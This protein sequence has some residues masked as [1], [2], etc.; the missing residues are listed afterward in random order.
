MST[1]Y[2]LPCDC[3]AKLE[4][5]ATESGLTKAC[6]CGALLQ[7]PTL[8]G[9]RQLEVVAAD[10]APPPSTWGTLQRGITVGT[11]IAVLGLGFAIYAGVAMGMTARE[12]HQLK[13]M[14]IEPPLPD[15]APPASVLQYWMQVERH[16][17]YAGAP[18]I[19][20]EY[21]RL[22]G[23]K[24]WWMAAGMVVALI[25]LSIIGFTLAFAPGRPAWLGRKRGAMPSGAPPSTGNQS[26]SN[27]S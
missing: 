2:L 17:L 19:V 10:Q 6:A 16:G 14:N 18:E 8:R 4:V 27:Q 3:G 12:F 26:A 23:L 20:G 15:N 7:V 25:G 22:R 13:K 5:D 1:K 11:V 21:H 24:Y 9:L